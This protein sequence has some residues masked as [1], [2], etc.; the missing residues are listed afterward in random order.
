MKSFFLHAVLF[1]AIGLPPALALYATS[2]RYPPSYEESV[3]LERIQRIFEES[4]SVEALTVGNSHARALDF[5]VTGVQG[6]ELGLPWADVFEVEHQLRTVVPHMPELEVVFI[7]LSYPSFHW[8]NELSGNPSFLNSRRLFYAAAPGGR[9]QKG[10]LGT[11]IEGRAQW[12]T[13]P[14]L[15]RNV[16]LGLMG[17][18]PYG[19]RR[20]ASE[21]RRAT[22]QPTAS[23]IRHA[24][25]R[26]TAKLEYMD[27]IA[28]ARPEIERDAY[29]AVSSTIRFL[30]EG[31]IDV[32]LY[33][34]PYYRHYTEMFAVDGRVREMRQHARRLEQ[35]HG[36][37]W[38]DFSRDVIAGEPA[39]FRDSDHLNARG[40]REFSRRL[41]D[42]VCR[43]RVLSPG[44]A[45][46]S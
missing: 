36:V 28:E 37:V 32:V 14:D 8:D 4:D 6:Q 39:M 33:T 16:V 44:S 27:A 35:E 38:L 21:K 23:L 10:D 34:P 24:E 15:W 41:L 5:G 45:L 46:C 2:F 29:Q 3:V 20:E 7:A 19:E 25:F 18:D 26:A 9:W 11:F 13:R 30:Q 40:Q 31:N 1:V 42:R 43:E 12:L 17:R 22:E